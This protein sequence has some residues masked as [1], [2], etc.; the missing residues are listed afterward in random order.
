MATDESL[1]SITT[2]LV[3]TAI[4]LKR[5]VPDQS[6]HPVL[7]L[8]CAGMDIDRAK[9][10]SNVIRYET[11]LNM[12]EQSCGKATFA[13]DKDSKIDR[14]KTFISIAKVWPKYKGRG[15]TILCSDDQTNI[16]LC[17]S[18][19][20]TDAMRLVGYE[21]K[22]CTC[23]VHYQ[24]CKRFADKL[25][26]TEAPLITDPL[27][28]LINATTLSI[29]PSLASSLASSHTQSTRPPINIT[30]TNNRIALSPISANVSRRSMSSLESTSLSYLE[31]P[32]Q[33]GEFEC[34]NSILINTSSSIRTFATDVSTST[35][36]SQ[37]RSSSAQAQQNKGKF[38]K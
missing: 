21:P 16:T 35:S 25:K 23:G 33:Q 32:T 36:A 9:D 24:T 1:S 14:F 27:S 19:R 26:G 13:I 20:M 30:S 11:T 38:D 29:R 5:L 10:S 37:S 31:S 17:T 6:F 3:N 12:I 7:A 2:R 8:I 34:S 18:K 4:V 22:E 28:L 15:L